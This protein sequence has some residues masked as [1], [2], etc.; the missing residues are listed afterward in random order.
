MASRNLGGAVQTATAECG[1]M[2]AFLP[3]AI[4]YRRIT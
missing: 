3:D 2:T 4:S 1:E